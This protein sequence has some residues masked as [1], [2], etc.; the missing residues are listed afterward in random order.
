M[1]RLFRFFWLGVFGVVFS[2]L[3]YPDET[4][5]VFDVAPPPVGYPRIV[6][7]EQIVTAGL[8]GLFLE[9]EIGNTAFRI[10]GLGVYGTMQ[11]SPL[12]RLLLS[13]TAG[14]A[15][16]VGDRMD[17]VGVQLPLRCT[18]VVEA[19][20]TRR[21]DAYLFGG[22]GGDIGLMS[23]TVTIPQWVPMTTTWID[24][25]TTVQTTTT[26]GTVY[27]GVQ[28]TGDI[29]PFILS[30]FGT[31]GYTAGGYRVTQTSTMS[32]DYPSTSGNIDGQRALFAGCDVLLKELNTS[33]S[34]L[35]RRDDEGS[36]L[37]VSIKRT[38]SSRR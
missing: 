24:D 3:A 38:L 4:V 21:L 1:A 20:D 26:T 13:A 34:T 19:A 14:G 18:A 12:D 9:R 29:G 28:F 35:V 32:Y 6:R 27:G 36:I 33:L 11:E 25:D 10:G 30:L 15:I 37:N 8:Q 23:M 5:A 7:G 22:A 16:L 31:Y 2:V 17:L